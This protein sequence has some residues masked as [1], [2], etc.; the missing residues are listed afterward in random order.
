LIKNRN[1]KEEHSNLWIS[2]LYNSIVQLL[3]NKT[4]RFPIILNP[5]SKKK[6]KLKNF[7]K[8]TSKV[9]SQSATSSSIIFATNLFKDQLTH[10]KAQ[11]K[12]WIKNTQT[13]GKGFWRQTNKWNK[14]YF[15]II[16]KIYDSL[17]LL[18][19]LI[20]NVWSSAKLWK[21]AIFKPGKVLLALVVQT[22]SLWFWKRTRHRTFVFRNVVLSEVLLFNIV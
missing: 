3:G 7:T 10:S 11:K 1:S 20:G 13:V 15:A 12:S 14:N 8:I 2:K 17:C 16:N 6:N 5:R 22:R 18:S 9:T 21:S 19:Q 4:S